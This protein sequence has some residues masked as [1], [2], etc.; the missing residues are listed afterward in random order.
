[1]LLWASQFQSTFSFTFMPEIY[2]GMIVAFPRHGI[3]M[4]VNEVFHQFDYVNG[5][6]TTATLMAPAAYDPSGSGNVTVPF[7]QGL[8]VGENQQNANPGAQVNG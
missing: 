3:Q 8:I 6:T 1:M 7:T 4:Y 5:F 2:P